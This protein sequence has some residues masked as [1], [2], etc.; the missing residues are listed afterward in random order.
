MTG[1]P[2]VSIVMPC[3]NEVVSLRHCITRAREALAEIQ[4][5]YGLA[6]EV[7]VADNGSTDG[8]QD[9]ARE[10]GARVV[11]VERRGYGAA[12]IEGFAQAHGR[13]LVMG[14]ADGSYDFL[15][16][17]PMVGALLDGADIC[18]GSRF[19][20]GIKPGAMPW[21][22]RYIGNPLLTGLLNVFFATNV[23]DAHCGLRA[24]TRNCL[25]RLRLQGAGMEFASEMVVKAVLLRQKIAEVPVTLHPDLRDRAPHLRPWRDGWRHLKFLMMLS[26]AWL[27]ILPGALAGAAGL[28]VLGVE[29]AWQMSG[30]GN[31]AFFGDYWAILA[32]SSLSV[33]HLALL[34]GVSAHLYGVG[35]GYRIAGPMFRRHRSKL[36]V[37]WML[38][39]GLALLALGLGVLAAVAIYWGSIRFQRIGTVLPAVIGTTL[40]ALGVQNALGGFLL[41][42]I[43]DD[44]QVGEV[45]ADEPERPALRRLVVA[46]KAAVS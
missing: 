37:E 2:D 42:L 9:L 21:K 25:G 35:R 33:G 31:T 10:L 27:F 5:T 32:G 16:A 14:D 22:N 7:V 17:A 13:F 15:E 45:E 24:L 26:P 40:T 28:S 39:T 1:T 4:Q 44:L 30:R 8:S 43:G 36:S 18:M 23:G 38:S 11:P 41:A 19:K 20:G 12:L 3:L 6:G 46:V 29:L 34:L